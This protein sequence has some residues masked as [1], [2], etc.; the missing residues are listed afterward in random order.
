MSWNILL[1]WIIAGGVL[2]G[3]VM[4]LRRRPRDEASPALNLLQQQ[5]AQLQ[6]Q[7][8]TSLEGNSS[9]LTEFLQK[10]SAEWR[11]THQTV[12]QR[13]DNAARVVSELT[14]GMSK[15]EEETRRVFEVGKDIASLQEL[16]RAP[17]ARGN[18]GEQFLGDLLTQMLPQDAYELQYEFKN[19]ERV[20]AVIKTAHGLVPVDSKFPLENF[21]K[22]R[23]LFVTDIKKHIDDISKKYIR[24][25]EGT[26]EFALMYIPAENV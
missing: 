2:V 26:F 23:K 5:L 24:P 19:G 21:Q 4:V 9:K 7:L 3:F 12:G 6:D 17:K 15:V 16:L 14:K 25:G 20:D 1:P 22:D 18:L 13:L 11:E 10:Q 8:R